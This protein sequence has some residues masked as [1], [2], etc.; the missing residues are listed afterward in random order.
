MYGMN[1]QLWPVVDV[2][3]NEMT[4]WRLQLQLD[5][6]PQGSMGRVAEY[7]A[8]AVD[9]PMGQVDALKGVPSVSVSMCVGDEQ[10]DNG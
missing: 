2:N 4:D 7:V 9:L 10:D 6:V 3:V 5:A 8:R 1:D